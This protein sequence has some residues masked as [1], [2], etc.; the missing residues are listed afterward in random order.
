MAAR[1]KTVHDKAAVKCRRKGKLQDALVSSLTHDRYRTAVRLLLLF[2]RSQG[3]VPSC[4]QDL[5]E[6]CSQ[7]VEA[8]WAEGESLTLTLQALAGLQWLLPI[9]T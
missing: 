7:F 8:S 2:W 4:L 9:A 6:A 5:D 3:F 1:Q